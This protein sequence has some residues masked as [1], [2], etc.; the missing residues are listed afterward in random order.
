[1]PTDYLSQKPSSPMTGIGTV[2]TTA[3]CPSGRPAMYA[4]KQAPLFATGKG[5]VSQMDEAFIPLYCSI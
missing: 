2:W 3:N 1:M 5:F 4:P